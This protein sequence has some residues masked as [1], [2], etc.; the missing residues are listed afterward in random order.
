MAHL[1]PA[2]A[3]LDPAKQHSPGRRPKFGLKHSADRRHVG[4]TGVLS[5]SGLPLAHGRASRLYGAAS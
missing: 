4:Y 2:T 5:E 1:A 3:D